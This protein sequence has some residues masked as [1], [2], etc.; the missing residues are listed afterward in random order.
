MLQSEEKHEEEKEIPS[1]PTA[2]PVTTGN[3]LIPS[4]ADARSDPWAVE[5]DKSRAPPMPEFTT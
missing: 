1:N 5:P 2:Q 4:V 3:I